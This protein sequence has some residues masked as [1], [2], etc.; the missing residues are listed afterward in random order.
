MPPPANTCKPTTTQKRL[1][2]AD[3]TNS[4]LSNHNLHKFNNVIVACEN[5]HHEIN[6]PIKW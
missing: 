4:T 5:P 3:T 6:T 2:E 1:W